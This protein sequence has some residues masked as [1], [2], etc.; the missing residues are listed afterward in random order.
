MENFSFTLLVYLIYGL[1]FFSMGLIVLLESWRLEDS[2]PQ[3]VIIRPLAFF[4]L[5]HGLHEWLEISYIILVRLGEPIPPVLPFIRL[6]LLIGSFAALFIYGILAYRYAHAHVSL[7]TLFGAISLPLFALLVSFDVLHAYLAGAIPIQ[8]VVDSLVRYL[9]GVPGA[10]VATLA[11]HASAK[12]ARAD[13]RQPI[14]LYLTITAFGFASYSLSQLFVTPMNT[15]LAGILNLETFQSVLYVP[16]PIF[17]TLAA[18]ITTSGLFLSTRFLEKERQQFIIAAQKAQ[19]DLL[20]QQEIMQRDLLRHV[21]AGQEEERTRIARELHDEMAQTLTAFSLE[22]AALQNG[23]GSRSKHHQVLSNLQELGKKMAEDMQRLVYTLRPAHLDS[24]GLA[25]ALR[26]LAD[27][28]GKQYDL[29]VS[30]VVKETT[31]RLDPFLETVIYRISQEALTN[32]ARHAQAREAC[33][34]LRFLPGE[35]QLEIRDRGIGF[36]ATRVLSNPHGWGL[37]GIR[38]RT[39]SVNGKLTIES[40]PGKGTTLLVVFPSPTERE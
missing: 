27:Q 36:D 18:I 21:V 12:K 15:F 7:F 11:L 3:K 10:A 4:G 26:F 14:D 31:R 39:E 34:C 20:E 19:M 40:Q 16:V 33:I 9:L 5:L 17:R 37:V 28:A 6:G 2:A 30:L 35:V 24:L 23:L 32:V 29:K 1:T 25:P 22:L 13:H 38:E 8:R